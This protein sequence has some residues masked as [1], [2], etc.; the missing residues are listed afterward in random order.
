MSTEDLHS[1]PPVNEK[2]QPTFGDNGTAIARV[3]G[4]QLRAIVKDALRREPTFGDEQV[5]KLYAALTH[6]QDVLASLSQQLSGHG[7]SRDGE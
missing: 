3:A 7:V 5:M 6:L 2:P 1:T 4:A